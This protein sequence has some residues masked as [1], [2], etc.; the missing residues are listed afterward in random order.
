MTGTV[1]CGVSSVDIADVLLNGKFKNIVTV[2]KTG[3]ANFVCSNYADDAT[4]IQAAFDGATSGSLILFQTGNYSITSQISQAGKNL[5]LVGIGN[6]TFTINIGSEIPGFS[7]IG[8][9]R[10]S[11][12]LSNDALKDATTINLTSVTDASVDDVI[13]LAN[14]TLWCPYEYP[15]YKTGESYLIKGIS[16]NTITLDSP[17]LRD[18]LTTN[19]SRA[20]VYTPI[21][22]NLKNLKFIGV[23]V[24]SSVQGVALDTC[25]NS[26]VS[27]CHFDKHGIAALI[28]KASNNVSIYNNYISNS[29]VEG[30]GYGIEILNSCT[31][32]KIFQN[33]MHNCRHCITS[34]ASQITERSSHSPV[35]NRQIKI[36]NNA[37]YRENGKSRPID[38]HCTTIDYDVHDNIIYL[39][40]TNGLD[41]G[42][43]SVAFSDGTFFSHFYNNIIY[44][45]AASEHRG[46]FNGVSKYIYNN[47]ISGTGAGIYVTDGYHFKNLIIEGN[48]V[49]GDQT[50]EGVYLHYNLS[51]ENLII[52]NN[53]IKD[54]LYGIRLDFRWTDATTPEQFAFSADTV[55]EICNNTIDTTADSGIYILCE[56]TSTSRKSI[57]NNRIHNTNRSNGSYYSIHLYN[58]K[59]CK[60]IGNYITD[61][62]AYADNAVKESLACD[63]NFIYN[64]IFEGITA[65]F[66]LLGS[67][68]VTD[69]NYGYLNKNYGT[70][71]ITAGQ[72]SVDVTHGLSAAPNRVILS[73]T[74]APAGKQYYISAKAATTFTIIIDS[75]HSADISFDWEAVV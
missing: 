48:T 67:H 51:V 32:I 59:Y 52:K 53:I 55:A 33:E 7:F 72:T 40:G 9:T 46:A 56:G 49:I 38:A 17:L 22:I 24:E 34:G 29:N 14:D 18:Y 11:T 20:Y 66:A 1:S 13:V 58:T 12:T 65:P 2:A 43:N 28:I 64:N 74:T 70:A 23:G 21:T 10:L 47:H 69:T 54:T 35:L 63:Y 3:R 73:P 41:V 8:T 60:I 5:D 27:N 42:V 26:S 25:V 61:D 71:T 57:N 68:N 50:V 37:I 16:G 44:D 19:N 15:T 62:T 36:Y 31:N 6:V 4:C 30:L 75:A 45:G 39:N